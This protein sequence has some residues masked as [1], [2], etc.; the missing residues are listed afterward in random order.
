MLT[1]LLGYGV[2]TTLLVATAALVFAARPSGRVNQALAALLLLTGAS[3]F[4]YERMRQAPDP[5]TALQHARTANWYDLPTVFLTVYVLDRLFAGRTR[6]RRLGVW[7][8]G[9]GTVAFLVANAI[10]PTL[11]VKD[12]SYGVRPDGS[13]RSYPIP[14]VLALA[15]GTATYL[16]WTLAVVVGARAAASRERTRLERRQAG[17]VALA[18][19][20]LIGHAAAG[21][22]ATA[23]LAPSSLSNV[24]NLVLIAPS[25]LG[26]SS[27]AFALAKLADPFDPRDR[28][29]LV[30]AGA[31][32]P[33]SGA[34]AVLLLANR[35]AL[36]WLPVTLSEVTRMLWVTGFS[37]T[38]AVALTRFGLAGF[39]ERIARRL[40]SVAFVVVVLA[41]V[42]I[43]AAVA[44]A[45]AGVTPAGLLL[46]PIVAFAAL[47][48]SPAPLKR[49]A[50]EIVRRL[51]VG[52]VD[53]QILAERARVYC[54]A[55]EARYARGEPLS[56][57]E[58]T[59][60]DL[61]RELEITDRE[62]QLLVQA[63]RERR[64]PGGPTTLLGR[65][66]V[67]RELGRGAFGTALLARD[68]VTGMQ[69]V[70]KRFHARRVEKHAL[71]EARAL[72]AVRH[73]RVVPLLDVER[74]DE[75]IFLV[76]GYVP[77]GSARTALEEHGPL[78]PE[79]AAALA[80]DLLDGLAALHAAGLVH[81]DVKPGNLLIDASGR[82]VLGDFGSARFVSQVDL[83][84]A[85]ISGGD[86][87]GSYATIAPETL[88]GEPATPRSD[89]Y[90][91]GAVLYR[92]LT[93][94]SYVDLTGRS[95][96]QA[97]QVI[98]HEPPRLPHARI[99][100]ALGVVI[101]RALAKRPIDRYASAVEMRVAIQDALARAQPAA[102]R[103]ASADD[104][105]ARARSP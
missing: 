6:A 10:E 61:R 16:A 77:G 59:L 80:I 97:R 55:L 13:T 29:W 19:S 40:A 103:A 46:A 23:L 30:A 34:L 76:L 79:R 65:Y 9:L 5:A 96:F 35:E 81:R 66:R 14:G 86:V 32:A 89:V 70:L 71:V 50:N 85:T 22:V 58:S 42:G 21:R 74:V 67:E 11:F 12:V 99:P 52:R 51:T 1:L 69:V 91:A 4:V 49:A 64:E 102:A 68:P 88:A 62:H 83:V 82:G 75:E 3:I 38:L 15:F 105:Q 31:L 60:R 44:L 54:A 43:P 87:A 95:A 98:L 17:L 101:A 63:V 100:A 24:T 41:V 33:V 25:V 39:G 27:V 45:V 56:A 90:S 94:E 36:P 7:A 53:A 78:Q 73:A 104:A 8:V 84:D 2:V 48:L 37:G 20:F 18:F 72:A 47:A 93:N 92:L 57:D 26:V 28:K